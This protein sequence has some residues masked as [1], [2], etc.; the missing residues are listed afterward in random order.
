MIL[1]CAGIPDEKII[2]ET[3]R[4]ILR[5]W[6]KKDKEQLYLILQKP[7]VKKY[8]TI[9][10]EETLESIEQF[11]KT[12]TENIIKQGY[13]YF[14]CQNK[15][16][17]ELMG[18]VGLNYVDWISGYP[19]PCHTVSWVLSDTYWGHGYATEAGK[20][21]LKLGF[22]SYALEKIHACAVMQNE[23]SE[24]VMKKIGMKFKETFDFPGKESHIYAK[25]LLY[26][27][28]KKEYATNEN[29]T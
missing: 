27:L 16:T 18:Y 21:L 22:E 10:G 12:S 20:A 2:L 11:I 13:G 3:E 28:S 9:H 6:H 19:F 4:L 26:A 24:K 8:L 29:I 17:G 14:A 1:S 7:A 5:T 23:N 25:H 15:E